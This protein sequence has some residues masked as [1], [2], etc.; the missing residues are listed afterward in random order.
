MLDR[1]IAL[2]DNKNIT[3]HQKHKEMKPKLL[4]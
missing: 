3:H 4:M 2:I 1:E